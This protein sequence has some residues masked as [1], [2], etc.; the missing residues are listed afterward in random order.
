MQNTNSKIEDY[1]FVVTH[2]AGAG[3]ESDFMKGMVH[4][5]NSYGLQTIPFNFPYMKI[6]QETGKRR[7]P[8]RM[9]KLIQAFKDQLE[10]YQKEYPKKKLVVGGKSMG[11]RVASLVAS[12]VKKTKDNNIS[13]CICL[14]FPFHPP[15]KLDKYRGDHLSD[16]NTPTLI[17]QGER[18]AFGTRAE[19]DGYS[20]SNSVTVNY[21]P[22]GDH[23]FKP[24]VRSGHTLD[25]NIEL[26]LKKLIEF[27]GSLKA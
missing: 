12:E 24:R 25:E 19:I 13:A 7:P 26:S 20:L 23:S 27:L 14:G 18:D 3:I 15:K 17:L 2:G 11:G 16:L 22:D 1:L 8:D 5:L 21:I 6:M 9:P 10:I 4:D